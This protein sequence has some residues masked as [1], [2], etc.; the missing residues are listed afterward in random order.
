[1][2][3]KLSRQEYSD[4]QVLGELRLCDD[5]GQL[6]F[7]CKT[8]ELAWKDNQQSVSCIPK[9]QYRAEPRHTQKFGDHFHVKALD[10]DEVH[11]RSHI[12]IHQGNF[13]TQ[14]EGCILVGK[15]HADINSDGHRDV[16]SSRP[17]LTE[18]AQKAPE[19]FALEITGEF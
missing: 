3:G 5:A 11:G 15:T 12:L 10:G 14:I 6:L 18:L 16:T 8:L 7:Q 4:K 13:H 9:G 19:G 17:T 2:Q 1:M